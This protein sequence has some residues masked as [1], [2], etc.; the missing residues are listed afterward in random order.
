[1]NTKLKIVEKNLYE[2][3]D[4]MDNGIPLMTIARNLGMKYST[5]KS[6][7]TKLKIDIKTNQNRKGLEH[8]ECR[9]SCIEYL[10]KPNVQGR[11]V[12]K[13]M[14][15]EGIKEYRCEKCKR[16]EYEGE[17]IPLEL[18]HINGNHYDNRLENLMLVCPNCHSI[19]HREMLN[20]KKN[21]NKTKICGSKIIETRICENPKC[22]KEFETQKRKQRFCSQEC[23]KSF[24]REHI[25]PKENLLDLFKE[26]KSFVGV[27]KG[28]SVSDNTVKKWFKHYGLP[29]SSLQLRR[30]VEE[31]YADM[32]K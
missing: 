29:N 23:Y 3:T 32:V 8:K 2:I 1:M 27:G 5:L 11:I 22:K 12:L 19:L 15:E 6:N 9:V 20:Q 21:T 17:K 14:I 28:F 18:H 30:Y 24:E 25:P 4:A 10:K 26:T 16:E 7:L 31:Y 13:K